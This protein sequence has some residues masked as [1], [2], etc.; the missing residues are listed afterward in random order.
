MPMS[1]KRKNF[2][3][4]YLIDLNGTQAAIRAGYSPKTAIQQGSRLLTY[5]DVKEAITEAQAKRATKSGITQERVLAELAKVGFA[6]MRSFITIDQ[7]G[8]AVIDLSA[9]PDDG[10]DAL[11]E[12]QTET[13]TER[14]SDGATVT[15]KTRI[16]LHDKLAA[17]DKIARHLG[18][19]KDAGDDGEAK[20]MTLIIQ[21]MAPVSDVRVTRSDA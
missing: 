13:R 12:V 19:F 16:K 1:E 17:L 6:S 11:S 21:A 3:R 9:T 20:P 18:M 4:E 14:G 2:V 8:E 10:L 15:R 7:D 5:A